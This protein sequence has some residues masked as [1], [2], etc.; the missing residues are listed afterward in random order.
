MRL[1]D[2]QI[3]VNKPDR[4]YRVIGRVKVH[5]NARGIWQGMRQPSADELDDKL[6]AAAIEM[7][8]NAVILR[9]QWTSLF[10]LWQYYAQG[11]AVVLEPDDVKCAYC[12]ELIKRDARICRFCGREVPAGD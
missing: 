6:R 11:V 3:H 5:I 1:D 2:V 8:A 9:T 12:A 4:P 10:P 7:G